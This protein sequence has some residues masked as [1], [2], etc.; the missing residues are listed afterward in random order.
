LRGLSA[1]AELLL[2]L[3]QGFTKGKLQQI[4]YR[5]DA[6]PVTK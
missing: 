6:L 1:I 2:E 4:F 5:P 3:L